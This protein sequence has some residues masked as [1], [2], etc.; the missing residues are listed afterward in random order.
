MQQRVAG[1]GWHNSEMNRSAECFVLVSA[2]VSENADRL[3]FLPPHTPR[4]RPDPR[5]PGMELQPNFSQVGWIWR[6]ACR[7]RQP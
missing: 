3:T 5:R 7:R 1:C 2:A 6:G 4:R